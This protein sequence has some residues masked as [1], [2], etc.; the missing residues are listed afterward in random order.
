MPTNRA[1]KTLKRKKKKASKAR[2]TVSKEA[3]ILNSATAEELQSVKRLMSMAEAEGHKLTKAKALFHL[4][5]QRKE[6]DIN[7]KQLGYE[8]ATSS[9]GYAQFTRLPHQDESK[10]TDRE[11]FRENLK[12]RLVRRL[13]KQSFD[14]LTVGG[15]KLRFDM[16]L[17]I[18]GYPFEIPEGE[19]HA[20]YE[21]LL[22]SDEYMSGYYDEVINEVF[23]E[24]QKIKIVFQ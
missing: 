18:D 15:S 10:G 7:F 9:D 3:K 23:E 21:P 20:D 12:A 19:N 16:A 14:E 17:A 5:Q 1:S 13:E 4:R 6:N 11:E 8:R 24:A 22:T 2:E